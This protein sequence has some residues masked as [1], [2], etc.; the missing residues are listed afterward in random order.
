MP[1]LEPQI[2]PNCPPLLPS[3]LHTQA[4]ESHGELATKVGALQELWGR[5]GGAQPFFFLPLFGGKPETVAAAVGEE[6]SKNTLS[7]PPPPSHLQ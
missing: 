3:A 6:V 5:E 1:S 2:S 7:S 4:T